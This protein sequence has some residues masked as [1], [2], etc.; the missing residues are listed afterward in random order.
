MEEVNPWLDPQM[1]SH[2][3][4]KSIKPEKVP[5]VKPVEEKGQGQGLQKGL[6]KP[7]DEKVVETRPNKTKDERITNFLNTLITDGLEPTLPPSSL[8]WAET[9]FGKEWTEQFFEDMK[10]LMDELLTS[11]YY[12]PEPMVLLLKLAFLLRQ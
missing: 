5:E 4:K 2:T 12:P 9:N 6:E 1:G 7:L 10:I 8:E 3:N 11:H